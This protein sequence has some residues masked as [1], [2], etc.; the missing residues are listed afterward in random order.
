MRPCQLHYVASCLKLNKCVKIAHCFVHKCRFY[1]FISVWALNIVIARALL[2]VLITQTSFC[3][4][5]MV[6]IWSVN[7]VNLF[8]HVW[9]IV[10]DHKLMSKLRMI[11]WR[12]VKV[13]CVS[14]CLAC[15]NHS[16]GGFQLRVMP[17]LFPN[18]FTVECAKYELFYNVTTVTIQKC[19]TN[20][21]YED[22]FLFYIYTPVYLNSKWCTFFVSLA[23]LRGC[24][25]ELWRLEAT[26]IIG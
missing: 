3:I 8:E 21:L 2:T 11:T 19:V 20:I 18:N 10:W 17:S 9:T 5:H 25:S 13:E 14:C 7:K 23:F 16:R 26:M 22:A 6:T 1:S 12:T 4:P 24:C 15:H